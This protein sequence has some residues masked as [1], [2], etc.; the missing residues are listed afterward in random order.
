MSKTTLF[1]SR[2]KKYAYREASQIYQEIGASPDGLSHEQVEAMREKYGANSFA[3]RKNDTTIRRVRRAF[4]NPF[5]IILFILGIISLV[6]DVFL[7]S[8]FAR[9]ATTAIIIFSMILISGAIRLIQE[10][11]AKKAAQQLNRLIHESI[12]VRREG[13]LIEIS[14]EKL[15]VGDIVL[16]SAGDRVP[17]DI[18]L[19]E[20]TD[21][22]IS[23]AAITGESAILE[24]NCRA[25]SYSSLETLTQLENL[26][27]MATTVISGKG[28]GIVLAVGKD[29]LY[30]SFAKPDSDDK[31]SFQ[32]GANSI[33]WVMLRFIAVLIP[34]VFALLG[35]TGGK[36]LESFAFAL[37]V[38]VGLMPEMLPMVITACLARGS[39]TM[40]R[41]QTIIK[42]INAMQGFGSMDVLCMDKT[43]T[44]TNESILLE[45]YMD[46]LGNESSEVLDLAFLNSFYHSGVR[47]PIDNAILACQTMPGRETHYTDLLTQYQKIDEIPFDYARKFVSTLVTDKN[48]ESQL[49]MKGDISHIVDRCSHVEYRGEILPIEKGGMQSVSS[50]VDEMLQDGMKVIA[51]AR[52]NVG[53]QNQIIPADETDMILMGYLA[54]FDAPKKTAKV[55]VA[56]LKRLKVTPKILTG[57]QAEV[58]VSVCRRVGISSETVLT[59]ANLDEMTDSELSAAVEEIHVFAELTPGQKVRLV[60][61]LGQNG[62]TVGFLGDGINDIPALCEANVG[63]SVDTAVDAAKDAADVVLLQKDLG[64]LEQGILEGR[65]TFTNML[66]YIKITASSN[67]GNIL[68]IVCASAF[69]PFLPMTSVQILLLNLLYDVLCIILP[70]D[71]V[72]EEETVS[73]RDWSGRMLGRFMLSFGP[74]SSLFDIVTFLFLYY[75]LCPMLCGGATYLNLTDPALRL[76]YVSLFQTGWFLESMWTQVLILHFL[77]TR[78]I[79]FVQSRPSAPVICITLA[80]IVAFT[81]ITFTKGASLFGLTKLPLWYFVFLLIVALL[82]MLLTTVVKTFYQKKYYELI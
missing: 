18:R 3:E 10:L 69:L 82:Y 41:K 38:A 20:V 71:N 23:Q 4:I 16:L 1:D 80:G 55:S 74:I 62:H 25:L 81:A 63:I 5:N 53:Q 77:R 33:A 21:L 68:S 66:K 45:Y 39:L 43:G 56:A 6:T 9:N 24:K 46:V 59:G 73:P 37:S 15:V 17:A 40:S 28:E 75:F 8:N 52:K 78:R 47:N 65:K 27:F 48:G 42:D 54:F 64:V 14:A 72:D 57:D 44:L 35:I 29:T 2:I 79:P 32:K 36:W 51:V 76:Q 30:G 31:K 67:F 26:A 11:R 60:S 13:E 19:T 22:F 58:A 34:I 61:A 12:T 49:I 70:W 7:V 50:V